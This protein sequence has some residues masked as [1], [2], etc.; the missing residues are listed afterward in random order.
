MR[1]YTG[2]SHAS[3]HETHG[4][5]AGIVAP[6]AFSVT[7]SE[8]AAMPARQVRATRP[9]RAREL[10]SRPSPPSHDS[11]SQRVNVRSRN[12]RPTRT[13]RFDDPSRRPVANDGT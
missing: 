2:D 8:V 6:N 10:R 13:E 7:R 11:D 12:R 9:R 3:A 5:L 4:F 1:S